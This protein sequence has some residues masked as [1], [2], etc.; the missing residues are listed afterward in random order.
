VLAGALSSLKRFQVNLHHF[1][2]GASSSMRAYVVITAEPGKARELAR[3]IASLVG[4]KMADAC[5]GSHDIFA[6]IEVKE[7]HELNNLVMDKIQRLE[8]VRNTNTH[9]A[10][11]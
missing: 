6:V 1:Q 9:I 4:V 11:E 3:Q 5:W 10:V 7:S 2:K 8:G